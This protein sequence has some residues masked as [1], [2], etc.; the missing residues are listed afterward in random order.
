MNWREMTD[1]IIRLRKADPSPERDER[2]KAL[3]E[4]RRHWA[5]S[6][7]QQPQDEQS[8]TDKSKVKDSASIAAVGLRLGIVDAGG[9]G[10]WNV[11]PF[12]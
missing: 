12:G 7:G 2:L 8:Q 9:I 4:S 11:Q 10:R 5:R 3:L 1:E 6:C